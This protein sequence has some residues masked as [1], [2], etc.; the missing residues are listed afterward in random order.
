[1]LSPASGTSAPAGPTSTAA[2]SS[3]AVSPPTPGPSPGVSLYPASWMP[4]AGKASLVVVNAAN[5]EITF[6]MADQ[7]H[8]LEAHNEEVAVFEPGRHTFTASDPRF[9][10]YNSECSLEADA[11]YYWYTDD[12]V[13]SQTCRKLWP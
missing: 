6:T 2:E 8:R 4:P 5:A 12:A 7:E 10:S 11:I 3:P 13:V 9:E 1:V